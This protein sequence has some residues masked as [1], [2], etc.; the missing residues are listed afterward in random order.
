MNTKVCGKV[1]KTLKSIGI[2]MYVVYLSELNSE[3]EGI[4]NTGCI[5]CRN[6]LV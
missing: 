2:L 1:Y 6:S 5:E 4:L 3:V